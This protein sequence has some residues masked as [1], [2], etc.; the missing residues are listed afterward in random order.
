[1]KSVVAATGRTP[2]RSVRPL[3][4][5]TVPPAVTVSV[6]A[7]VIWVTPSR[8]PLVVPQVAAVVDGPV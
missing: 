5:M 2:L 3:A 1:M 6:A 7:P 8:Q 4:R